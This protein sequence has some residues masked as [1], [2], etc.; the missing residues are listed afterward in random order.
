MLY[1]EDF[2]V[3]PGHRRRGIGQLLFDAF[4]AVARRKKCKLVTWQVLDWNQAALDF[5]KKYKATIEK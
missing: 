3:M 4:L 1:L 2:V 5:Y